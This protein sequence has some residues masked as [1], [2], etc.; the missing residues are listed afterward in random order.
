MQGT[1]LAV[2]GPPS[3]SGEQRIV[4]KLPPGDAGTDATVAAMIAVAREAKS[5]RLVQQLAR[6]LT[7]TAVRDEW[8][9]LFEWCRQHITFQRD[10]TKVELIRHPDRIIA[11][12]LAGEG[13]RRALADCDDMATL[14]ASVL[15]ALGHRPVIVVMGRRANRPY[16]HVYFGAVKSDGTCYPMDPQEVQEPGL[17]IPAIRRR[18]YGVI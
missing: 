3:G 5:A 16:E 11:A 18:V 7:G 17:E 12:V 9:N 2:Q 4:A 8:D 1:M 13:R 14:G 15:L 6:F 10:P